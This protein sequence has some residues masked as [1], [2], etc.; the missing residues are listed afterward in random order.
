M[1]EGTENAGDS[2]RVQQL[3]QVIAE[4][5]RR[6]ALH[7]SLLASLERQLSKAQLA[8]L[9]HPTPA[10]SQGGPSLRGLVLDP[11]TQLEIKTLRTRLAE[12][13]GAIEKAKEAQTAQQ[14]SGQSVTGQRLITKCR[15]LQQENAELGRALAEGSLL[16]ATSQIGALKK[17]VL[18]LKNELRQLRE[19][20]ADLDADNEDLS[21]K[22]QAVFVNFS[23]VKGERDS[24]KV[25]VAELQAKLKATTNTRPPRSERSYAGRES[26]SGSRAEPR[27][28]SRGPSVDWSKRGG[29][30]GPSRD[31]NARSSRRV[32]D[33][34]RSPE[35][36]ARRGGMPEGPP[37]TS[38]SRAARG[39]RERERERD[40]ER[41]RE[42]ERER[43]RDRE[44]E[45][46]QKERERDWRAK[47]T[48]RRPSDDSRGGRGSASAASRQRS[49]AR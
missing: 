43:D 45:R 41:E 18:F 17:H 20:N 24:L 12:A 22:L 33:R 5:K 38:H 1:E 25:E 23:E 49:G 7:L 10:G 34:E 16:P 44:R 32:W 31:K 27:V 9:G 21:Q 28:S 47:E 42:R 14:F 35:G 29:S 26:P 30:I 48:H 6:E 2:Q 40:R 36:H 13:E 46:E 19:L 3:L 39:E 8:P 4:L 11:A 15:T 37:S